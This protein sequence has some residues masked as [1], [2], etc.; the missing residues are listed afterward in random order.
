[1]KEAS[2]YFIDEETK[3]EAQVQILKCEYQPISSE[4]LQLSDKYLKK[5]NSDK[6]LNSQS[7]SPDI[8][9]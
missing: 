4:Y 7:A 9:V 5:K 3:R 8:Q 2:L 1:M 6:Y